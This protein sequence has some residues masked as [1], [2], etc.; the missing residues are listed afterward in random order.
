MAQTIFDA[1][2][3]RISISGSQ[4]TADPTRLLNTVTRSLAEAGNEQFKKWQEGILKTAQKEGELAGATLAPEYRDDR[5]L[6]SEAFNEAAKRSYLTRLETETSKNM[7]AIRETYKNDPEG[8]Q[9]ASKQYIDGVVSGLKQNSQT[10]AAAEFMQARLQLAQ[11]SDGYMVSKTYMARQAEEIEVETDELIH[12]LNTNA[13]RDAGGLFSKDPQVQAMAIEK[14]AVS[15]KALENALHTTLPDG[16]PVYSPK[17]VEAHMNQ[18]HEKFYTRAVQDYVS[19]NDITD[20]EL[21]Q[22][23]DGSFNVNIE[24]M[25]SINL[26]NELGTEKYER[27]VKEWTFRKIREQDAAQ[28]KAE[29]LN[30]KAIKEMQ[31]Q[32][33]VALIGELLSGATVTLDGVYERLNAGMISSSDAMAAV[34]II[35]DPNAGSDDPDIVADLKTKLAMGQEVGDEIRRYAPYMRGKTY[36]SLMEENA[37]V[38]AGKIDEAENWIVDQVLEKDEFG[39]PD[40]NSQKQA[41]DIQIAYRQMIEDGMDRQLAYEKAQTLVDALKSNKRTSTSRVPRYAV[42]DGE[43]GFDIMATFEETEKAYREGRISY[44][45]MMAEGKKLT[46]FGAALTE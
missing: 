20:E 4:P 38:Q 24:G 8:Y 41:A 25:G 40:P 5:T 39:W 29:A 36:T 15:K 18:F 44:E 21:A 19:Q 14:F 46:A 22:I 17:A 16:T 2:R 10:A 9:K 27:E 1:Q 6:S 37:Q 30:E 23:V 43:G 35:T 26:L 28:Q 12:T 34:K 11:Q 45:E 42:P 31:K 33:G 32:N 13:Y 3:P 7:Q